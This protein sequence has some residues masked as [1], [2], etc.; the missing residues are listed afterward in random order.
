MFSIEEKQD[1]QFITD[2]AGHI[3][4]VS[5]TLEYSASADEKDLPA[6]LPDCQ[7]QMLLSTLAFAGAQDDYNLFNNDRQ[8][9]IK[10]IRTQAFQDFKFTFADVT[11]SCDFESKGLVPPAADSDVIFP[12]KNDDIYY[13]VHFSMDK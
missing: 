12:A 9:L 1:F 11:V 2:E 13:Y 3:Q 8:Q 10:K 6:W 5:F 7:E 4:S